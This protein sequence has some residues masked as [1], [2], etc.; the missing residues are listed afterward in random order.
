MV[1]CPEP[2]VLVEQRIDRVLTWSRESPKL[3]HLMRTYMR[4]VDAIVATS[5]TMPSFFDI[6]TA[7]GDQLTLLGKRLGW[8]RCHCV[9]TVQP[10]FGFACDVPTDVPVSG[11][12]DD[13]SI[14]FDCNPFG[15]ADVCIND[16]EVYRT[17]LRV[18]RFQMLALFD[19]ESLTTTV[20]YFFGPTGMVLEAGLGRVVI[21]PGRP[22]TDAETALLQLYPRVLPIAPG[23]RIRFHFDSVHV[24]GFGDGWG[25][26]CDE[27]APEGLPIGTENGDVLATDAGEIIVTSPLF[28]GAPWMCEID[29]KPYDCWGYP[30][31]TQP[32]AFNGERRLPTA[33]EREQGFPCGPADRALFNN[34]LFT[35]ESEIGEVITFAGLSGTD[36]DLTQLRQAIEA[37]IA[38]ATGGGDTSQFLLISQA[39]ARLPIFPEIQSVDGKITCTS[40]GAGNVRI[41]AGTPFQHRG[42]FPLVTSLQDFVTVA[43]KTYHLRWNPTDGFTLKD[44]ADVAYNP[45]VAA[46]SNTGFDSTYDNML[47]ARVVTNAANAPTITNLVNRNVLK[48]SYTRAPLVYSTNWSITGETNE[49]ITYD[50]ARTPMWVMN[51]FAESGINSPPANN[52]DGDETNL[53]LNAA[54]RYNGSVAAWSFNAVN[55]R[56]GRPQYAATFMAVG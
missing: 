17:F 53:I 39:R 34:R 49:I 51:G 14:W 10:V 30:M 5:C 8:P 50:F 41:P 40:T 21:A 44:L 46:E 3:L 48:F 6:D 43:S 12:C 37:L 11:F 38:A 27:L 1:T 24:F 9:C 4:Q 19:L 18:R 31:D 28:K 15:T 29:V 13:S 20:Q 33:T 23:I 32:F 25:G 22:L 52:N 56:A 42:I 47:V 45:T 7:V 55:G 35:T 26:F 36:G 2:D 16:D 54:S